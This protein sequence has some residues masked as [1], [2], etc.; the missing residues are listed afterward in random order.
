[1][2]TAVVAAASSTV[3][4]RARAARGSP[5]MLRPEGREARHD[6]RRLVADVR[7]RGRRL[8]RR[9]GFIIVA[10]APRSPRPRAAR[11]SRLTDGSRSSGRRRR[12]ARRHPR[13]ARRRHRHTT[14]G[15]AQARAARA[16]RRTSS[17]SDG[18]GR[19]AIR[20]PPSH[21]Q[22]DPSPGRPPGRDPPDV[23]Q[24]DPQLLG[25]R[26]SRGK[27]DIDPRPA[28]R[29]PLHAAERR[30]S[31]AGECA[32]FCGLQHARHGLRRA[33]CEPPADFDRWL[34]AH[35]SPPIEPASELA[36]RGRRSAFH[37]P[38]VRRVPHD[39]RA[40]RR[41]GTRRPRPHRLRIAPHASAPAPSRTR[42]RTSRGG[43]STRS[44][45]SREPHAADLDCR[46]RDVRRDRRLPREPEVDDG[47]H[48]RPAEH[49]R[50]SPTSELER[51]LGGRARASRASSRPSITSASAC[52]TSTRRSSSSSSPGS[53][54]SSCARSSR[55]RTTTSLAP[56]TYNEFFTM[57]GT[58]MIF[59][60]NTPVLAGLRQLPDPAADRQPRH[61]VPAAERVQLLDLPVRRASS[62][63]RA[64]SSATRPTAAGSPTCRS[65]ARRTR[66][67]IN[68][69]FWGL[70]DHLRR[71][72]HDGR[73][74]EL[75][76]HDLQVARAGHDASTACRS[77]CGRCSCSRSW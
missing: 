6:R 24:R 41:Q 15:A 38:V 56:E 23:R 28:Q 19:C 36:A 45:S 26:S 49:R 21:R 14:S 7:A 31:T 50:R 69:D 1:M 5:S 44:R 73:R 27:V 37:A 42:R 68:I 39:S 48:R 76:R 34:A 72:L 67:G 11:P 8:R 25:A 46:P 52:A 63:T 3:G 17:A 47:R 32:E 74:G 65:P 62:C 35:A 30:A 2:R 58:T 60:F 55:S 51:A 20:A 54:R 43:S 61:G 10:R 33:S 75:H 70:G 59:L 13:G 66:P 4:A 9:R 53:S 29:A 22:R 18:G 77:S 71:H 40:R 64:S 12:R 16:A 57:H